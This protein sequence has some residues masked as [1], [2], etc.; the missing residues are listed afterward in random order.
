MQTAL[1]LLKVLR[2]IY[3]SALLIGVVIFLLPGLGAYEAVVRQV[4]SDIALLRWGIGLA[5]FAAVVECIGYHHLKRNQ[6]IMARAL[7]RISPDLRRL[8]AIKILVDALR[9][10]KQSVVENA[11]RELTRLTGESYGSDVDAWRRWVREAE[12]RPELL[13]PFPAP[14]GDAR[15]QSTGR[16]S[17]TQ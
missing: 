9:S 11:L 17:V 10:E 7:M 5:L 12:R 6:A 1:A 8:E 4:G 15:P 13:I 2:A 16:T 14:G 3:V